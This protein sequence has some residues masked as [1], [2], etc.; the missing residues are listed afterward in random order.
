VE[1]GVSKIVDERVGTVIEAYQKA[2]YDRDV[3]AF[4]LLYHPRAR[5]FDAWGVWSYEGAVAWLGPV[6]GWLSS[7]GDERV[8]VTVE[9]LQVFGDRPLAGR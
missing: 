8:L 9:N 1:Y 7:L 3:E 5:V 4:M 6:E 2:V